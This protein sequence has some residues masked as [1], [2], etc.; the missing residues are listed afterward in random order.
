MQMVISLCRVFVT[1]A[2]LWHKHIHKLPQRSLQQRNV[3]T[4]PDRCVCMCVCDLNTHSSL[5]WKKLREDASRVTFQLPVSLQSTTT[6]KKTLVRKRIE[7]ILLH[8]FD[9]QRVWCFCTHTSAVCV[10]NL[11]QLATWTTGGSVCVCGAR[12]WTIMAAVSNERSRSAKSPR[13]NVWD[14]TQTHTFANKCHCS[15]Q[16]KQL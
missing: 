5:Q 15:H 16:H 11:R 4:H 14:E 3:T 6:T 12:V 8:A 9:P 1:N 2:S 7:T 10:C 13:R